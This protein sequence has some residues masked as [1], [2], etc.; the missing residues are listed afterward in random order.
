[1][2]MRYRSLEVRSLCL[3]FPL[4][5]YRSLSASF[6]VFSL[7]FSSCLSLFFSLSLFS[8]LLSLLFLPS[9]FITINSSAF[10]PPS[11]TPF[12][13]SPSLSIYLF[14]CIRSSALTRFFVDP[15][16]CSFPPLCSALLLSFTRSFLI[17][18]TFLPSV[19]HSFFFLAYCIA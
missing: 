13:F 14:Q 10:L 18:A 12:P 7:C 16:T 5:L 2:N 4:F 9:F 1:M 19:F 8:L 15:L 6:G 3:S 11:L 17:I